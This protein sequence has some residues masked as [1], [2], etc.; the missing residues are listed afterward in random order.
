MDIHAR[1]APLAPQPGPLKGAA[2]RQLWVLM[3]TVFVDMIGFTIVL[4]LLPF[5]ATRFGARPAMVGVLISAF[6]FAQ[7]VTSPFWGRLSDR[8]GRRPMILTGLVLSAVAY[9]LFGLAHS[10]VALFLSRLVQGMGS[11]TTGVVQ[12]YVSD[13]IAPEERAKALGWVTAAT[14]LGVTIGPLIGSFATYLG[15]AAPGYLAA[16]LCVANVL[17][18]ARWLP[19][20]KAKDDPGQRKPERRLAGA[21]WDVFTHPTSA[22]GSLIWLYAIGMMA[23]MA[24]NGVLALYLRQEYAVNERTIGWFYT[25][26][27]AIG[28]VMRAV[29][30]GPLVRRFGEVGVMRL[31]TLALASGMAILPVPAWLPLSM[32]ARL[33]ALAFVV[34]LMP[35]G[36]ALLFPSTTALVSRRSPRNETGQLMG[37]QQ[38]FGGV[39]RLLGPMWSTAL[40]GWRVAAPFWAA[41]ALMMGGRLLTLRMEHEKPRP[42]S[43]GDRT[44][45][46]LDVAPLASLPPPLVGEPCPPATE[47]VASPAS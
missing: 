24:M 31:G 22:V 6:A 44:D 8:Y 26:V 4:P 3:A 15:P 32:P 7:L 28:V 9:V 30:L 21:L 16:G 20:S 40:F 33:A 11:G 35:V 43:A 45:P 12:A 47:P 14:S 46:D 5:Y 25:Y 17:S 36:T 41:A 10:L 1:T 38:A 23:F 42:P 29:L 37:V 2:V 13:S 19:E 18:A 34:L 27:G 39:S